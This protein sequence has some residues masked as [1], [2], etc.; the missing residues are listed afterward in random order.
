V[1]KT[2]E[3]M[4]ST[5]LT[6][7]QKKKNARDN[8]TASIEACKTLG[9]DPDQAVPRERSGEYTREYNRRYEELR[10]AREKGS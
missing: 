8:K 10:R 2:N 9:L 5:P 4:S 1:K 7:N 6:N 3:T